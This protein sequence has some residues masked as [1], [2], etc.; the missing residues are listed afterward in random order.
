MHPDKNFGNVM[1]IGTNCQCMKTEILYQK[2][3]KNAMLLYVLFYVSKCSLYIYVYTI[4]PHRL[5]DPCNFITFHLN[6]KRLYF[7]IYMCVSVCV[8]ECACTGMNKCAC[9]CACSIHVFV[10]KFFCFCVFLS[11]QW[12]QIWCL[13]THTHTYIY[14]LMYHPLNIYDSYNCNI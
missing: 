5:S 12:M 9:T 10:S 3:T 2:W 6:I 13:N 14:I 7:L 11:C 8:C 1:C 4:I